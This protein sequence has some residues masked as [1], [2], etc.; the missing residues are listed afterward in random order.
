MS[1]LSRLS[2][3]TGGGNIFQLILIPKSDIMRK[4]ET[5]I[6]LRNRPQKNP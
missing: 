1:V 6:S 2:K 4:V 3:S 5:N